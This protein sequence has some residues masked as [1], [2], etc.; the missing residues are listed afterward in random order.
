MSRQRQQ[1]DDYAQQHHDKAVQLV[2]KRLTD[3]LRDE[4]IG[5]KYIAGAD[6]AHRASPIESSSA[7]ASKR[8]GNGS[9]N[10]HTRNIPASTTAA[11]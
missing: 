1:N 6:D 3:A 5:G 8:R 7:E 2:A 9:V 4:H 11:E 10:R